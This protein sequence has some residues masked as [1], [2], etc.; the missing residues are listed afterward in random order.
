MKKRIFGALLVMCMM[1]PL[2]PVKA[3]AVGDTTTTVFGLTVT[4]PSGGFDTHDDTNAVGAIMIKSAG[5]YTISGTYVDTRSTIGSTTLPTEY[6]WSVGSGAN[7]VWRGII[8][9]TQASGD[10]RII[11]NNVDVETSFAQNVPMILS[12][13]NSDNGAA[14]TIELQGT[15]TL[16]SSTKGNVWYG[17]AIVKQG[18]SGSLT[19]TGSGD[20]TASAQGVA[21]GSPAVSSA[22]QTQSYNCSNI[23]FAQTGAITATSATASSPAVGA[24]GGIAGGT[25]LN[26][27]ARNIKVQ[28]G[29]LNLS[30]T[31]SSISFT[32]AL[33]GSGSL[34]S[35]QGGGY[36]NIN[37]T[38][39]KITVSTPNAPNSGLYAIGGRRDDSGNGTGVTVSGGTIMLNNGIKPISGGLYGAYVSTSD[40]VT[41][42]SVKMN[43]ADYTYTANDVEPQDGK[44]WLYLPTGNAAVT[45]NGTSYYGTV[46]SSNSSEL[47][48]YFASVTSIT[49]LPSTMNANSTITLSGT[50]MPE[51]AT[52]RDVRYEI[53]DAGGTG[54]TLSGK[55][56]TAAGGGTVTLRAIVGSGLG[57]TDY[58]QVFSV[59]VTHTALTDISGIPDTLQNG[60][61]VTLAPSFTP[62]DASYRSVT[63]SVKSGSADIDGNRITPTSPGQ[64][65]LTA[66]VANGSAY[67]TAFTKDFTITVPSVPVTSIEAAVPSTLLINTPLSLSSSV[68]PTNASYR[69]VAW[70]VKD[71]GTTGATITDNTLTATAAGTLT[72]TATVKNGLGMGKN[73]TEDYEISVLG[74]DAVLNLASGS[75][76]ITKKN[77]TT[78]TVTYAGYAGGSKDIPKTETI[79]I[80]GTATDETTQII[81]DGT[82][83]SIRLKD[84]SMMSTGTTSRD[85]KSCIDLQNGASLTLYAEGTNTLNT[86][87]NY[88]GGYGAAIHVPDGTTLT[89]EDGGGMLSAT[90]RYAAAIGGTCYSDFHSDSAGTILIKG[91][92]VTASS[93]M[94]AGIG[95][96]YGSGTGGAGGTITISGGTVTASSTNGA[97]VGGGYGYGSGT[98]GA[99]GTITIS[100]GT[101][102]ASGHFGAG[103]GGGT[104]ATGGAGG[105][106]NISGG[107][108]T[109]S[110]T[111]IGAAIG[112]GG[113]STGG[114]GGT[115][116]ISG[117]TV[118]AN[119]A[120][121]HSGA[122]AIGGGCN[123]SSWVA[124]DSGSLTITGG[125]VSTNRSITGGTIGS[126]TAVAATSDG[127]TRVYKT[128]VNMVDTLGKNTALAGSSSVTDTSYGFNDVSTDGNGKLYLYLPESASRTA[129]IGGKSGY[130]GSTKTDDSGVLSITSGLTADLILGVPYLTDAGAAASAT[131]TLA[132]TVYYLAVKDGANNAY[133]T[134]DELKGAPGVKSISVTADTTVTLTGMP[135][136]E[137]E[138][139]VYAALISASGTYKSDVQTQNL[140]LTPSAPAAGDAALDYSAETLKAADGLG[141]SLQYFTNADDATGGTE[142]TAAGVSITDLIGS[143]VYIRKVFTDNSVGGA[144]LALDIPARPDAPAAPTG[145]ATATGI[146]ATATDGVEYKL[147][148]GIWQTSDSFTGL[149]A[150]KSYTL[151]ARYAATDS[152]FASNAASST[153]STV[154]TVAAP[155][156][157]GGG[158][159]FAGNTVTADKTAVGAGE[160]VTYTVTAIDGYTPTLTVDGTAVALTG[161]ASPYTY[162]CTPAEGTENIT[163]E[164]V[165]AG[166]AISSISVDPVTIF[167]DDAH[168]ASQDTLETYL[169][170]LTA[171]AKDDSGTVLGML[172]LT[173]VS[174]TGTWDAKGGTYTYT[175]TAGNGMACDFIVTVKPVN[176]AITAVPDISLMVKP[177]DGYAS[178]EAIGLPTEL[179]VTY[180]GDGYTQKTDSLAVS[181]NDVPADFGKSAT[182]TAFTGTLTLPAWATG[183][184]T[185]AASVT[186]TPKNTA[187]VKVTQANGTYSQTPSAPVIT[188]TDKDGNALTDTG[189]QTIS[190]SG[191][192]SANATYGP[193][194]TAPTLP[195]SYIVT[196]TYEDDTNLGTGAVSFTITKATSDPGVDDDKDDSTYTY[197]DTITLTATPVMLLT[198]EEGITP[199]AE[200][201]VDFYY[202]KS[203]TELVKLN[204][205][206]SIAVDDTTGT[207]TFVYDTTARL[208]PVGTDLS[209]IAA[210]GGSDVLT[211]SFDS[212]TVT[213]KAK[214]LSG[215]IGSVVT[216]TYDGSAGF[217]NV[218]VTLGGKVE[219]ADDVTATASLTTADKNADNDK[220]VATCVVTLDGADKAWYTSPTALTGTTSIMPRAITVASAQVSDKEYDGTREATVTAVTFGDLA[221]NE[222]LIP[223]IDYTASGEFTSEA[224]NVT[225]NAIVTVTLTGNA[226]KNY[227]F[228]NEADGKATTI[229]SITTRAVSGT[230]II[231]LDHDRNGDGIA[232]AGDT[233]K[234]TGTTPDAALSY[235]WKLNDVEV[236]T[237]ATYSVT[238]A[239]MGKKLAV[240]IT[241]SGNYSGELSS[242]AYKIGARTLTGTVEITGATAVGSVL[243]AALTST[244]GTPAKDTDYHVQ[245]YREAGGTETAIPDATGLTY[246]LTD[247]DLGA[248]LKV[249]L[250]ADVDTSVFS[251]TLTSD[252]KDIPAIAPS[253]AVVSATAGDT[254]VT[255][256]WSTPFNG[257]SAITGYKLYVKEGNGSYGAAIDLA[258]STTSYEATDLTNGTE[259]TFR[260]EAINTK[261]ATTSVEVAA[262]PS[263]A[264]STMPTPGSSSTGAAVVSLPQAGQSNW[265]V[266]ALLIVG[267]SL[268]L[269]GFWLGRKQRRSAHEE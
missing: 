255:L 25:L 114:A 218:A 267:M 215:D 98:G 216:K 175:A 180:T 100:G 35:N 221:P 251:G 141:Y 62:A 47:K 153:I 103:I 18:G 229:A 230:P 101:V 79:V 37:I 159:A 109:A 78:N 99:G 258:A 14:V 126:N 188:V 32:G 240:T 197:G 250:T 232:D 29:T 8:D 89:L 115:V 144:A 210:Y 243:T 80:T 165:F 173:D 41:S 28:S 43:G 9:T 194:A 236:S 156:K 1:L 104:G 227:E 105:I 178:H 170:T 142:I 23:T 136:Q 17:G 117:G 64:L 52:F 108:V 30:N 85:N 151:S 234:V 268:I 157:S 58:T 121:D 70:S 143:T 191:T 209:I 253:A 139:T 133:A 172:P 11:L 239:D 71:A 46:N 149:T 92:T 256:S 263:P 154:A 223:G 56:L 68:L 86:N 145:T 247:A 19:F 16:A 200:N 206:G 184:N 257:G 63:W 219:A 187:T 171:T 50:A 249:A 75:I 241:G 183:V 49:G 166:A 195:G 107:V 73:F 264:S 248:T 20:L 120:T 193:S 53:A 152:A 7:G 76:T 34:A 169:K 237:D 137:G 38:G 72:L 119:A 220:T 123:D 13:G 259:Y 82:T 196:V 93:N 94:G 174:T 190:Y 198:L 231:T 167:A 91:G 66:T 214:P 203:A 84:V 245:W 110:S 54:A 224:A 217:S 186:V 83:A 81:V 147:D 185:T 150:V 116:T 164:A 125:S 262:T 88:N 211:S 24:A 235:S 204:T 189:K 242:A 162:T 208:L 160:T 179:T 155:T 21:I 207:A 182:T 87:S 128:T 225:A 33:L 135:V 6:W 95:G 12:R 199:P 124:P 127:T 269:S 61:A 226:A 130:T 59:T 3:F 260:L 67:G 254:K 168:N 65:V 113:G 26:I 201:T 44:V 161:T 238:N 77:A 261:G 252:G 31:A 39:G 40:A 138:Y 181:W 177:D 266:P 176:A 233:L 69:T 27:T 4:G 112:G 140:T 246:T 118:T 228:V 22:A 74:A 111:Y 132:G 202:Q 2:L 163:A 57:K 97:G 96:G 55:Q 158:A 205:S 60:T 45:L 10:V 122:I 106:I 146:T 131:P 148:D 36:N 51:T 48:T 15:N 5:T 42:L 192:T 129:T 244:S 222:S 212:M 90:S 213:L 134:A 265:P 102:N